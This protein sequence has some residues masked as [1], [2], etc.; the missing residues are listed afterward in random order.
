MPRTRKTQGFSLT[1]LLLAVAI[2]GILSGIAIPSY[3]GQ[4]ARARLIGDAQSTAQMLRMQLEAYKADNGTY[5]AAGTTYTWN[6][7]AGAP[8]G[9]LTNLL[10]TFSSGSSKMNLSLA[11]QTP[12]LSYILTVTDPTVTGTPAIYKTDQTGTTL[13]LN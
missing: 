7:N 3:L 5:G 2:I 11:V 1:E 8:A 6:W 12:A 4:R 13:A 10:P 9:T